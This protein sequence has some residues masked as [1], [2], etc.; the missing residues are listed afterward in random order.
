M[1]LLQRIIECSEDEVDSII[2]KAIKEA[3]A[4]AEKV[5]RLGFLEY[6]KSKKVFKGFIPLKTRIKY[7]NIDITDYGMET[8][9]FIYEFAHFIRKNKI[10]D[11][12]AMIF[13]LEPFL[14]SYFGYPGQTDRDTIFN[15]IA[16][17]TTTTDDEYF[18][19]LKKNK[20]GD[21]KG[22]G[23]AMCTE[24]SAL[25]QQ[26]L[27]IF[28]TETYYCMGYTVKCQNGEGHCFNIV[29]REN[30]YVLLDYSLVVESI[31]E[32][33]SFENYYPF[34]ATLTNEEFLD[35]INNETFKS[36][37]DYY[38]KNFKQ[39]K[40]GTQRKYIIGKYKMP[41]EKKDPQGR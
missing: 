14:N 16:W 9:D 2:E 10:N 38:Y 18:A 24:R 5:D 28:G 8:T 41:E 31:R 40:T 35:F 27:S 29:K 37:D 33:G 17:Q 15:D 4:N 23:A 32:N 30:D 21:L 11:K 20:L 12:K 22:K 36:F 26:I 39:V 6:G 13:I 1:D 7:C 19:A 3:D 34:M 25:V